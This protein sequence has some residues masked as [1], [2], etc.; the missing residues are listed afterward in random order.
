MFDLRERRIELGMTREEFIKAVAPEVK[1]G[2]VVN[3]EIHRIRLRDI[4]MVAIRKIASV[5]NCKINDLLPKPTV[6]IFPCKT[7]KV[8]PVELNVELQR[9]YGKRLQA[10]RKADIRPPILAN[11]ALICKWDRR[12][13]TREGELQ[14]ILLLATKL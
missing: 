11:T 13:I 1:R 4:D 9:K 6:T 8:N 12:V 5:L 10:Q 2:T 7:K 14:N 3:I